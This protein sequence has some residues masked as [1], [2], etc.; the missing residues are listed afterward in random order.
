MVLEQGTLEDTLQPDDPE[1][2][3]REEQVKRVIG[4][5][6]VRQN[7]RITDEQGIR[8]DLEVGFRDKKVLDGELQQESRRV[9]YRLQV[10]FLTKC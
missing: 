5:Q 9:Y 2:E 8:E 7:E 6:G 4:A 3:V 1:Q 10:Y